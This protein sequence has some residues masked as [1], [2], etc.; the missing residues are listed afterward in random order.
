VILAFGEIVVCQHSIHPFCSIPL[1][2]IYSHDL[3]SAR[4]NPPFSSSKSERTDR[5]LFSM[6]NLRGDG[7]RELPSQHHNKQYPFEWIKPQSIAYQLIIR[8]ISSL[9]FHC[10]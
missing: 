8:S 7:L 10:Q 1:A 5:E 9:G 6:K 3:A 4:P 2:K